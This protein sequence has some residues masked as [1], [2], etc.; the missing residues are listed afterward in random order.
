MTLAG[1]PACVLHRRKV[2]M[3]RDKSL[4]SGYGGRLAHLWDRCANMHAGRGC[5]LAAMS[6][7]ASCITSSA[8][9]MPGSDVQGLL[10][11]A[12]GADQTI[13]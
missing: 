4:G 11:V 10:Q 5:L 3:H 1:V 13:L 12:T 9:S 6:V 8:W 7:A 2:C